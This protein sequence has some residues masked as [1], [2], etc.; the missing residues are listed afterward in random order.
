[1]YVYIYM[2]KALNQTI[3]LIRY[4]ATW[5]YTHYHIQGVGKSDYFG[6]EINIIKVGGNFRGGGGGGGDLTPQG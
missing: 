6:A 5:L 1:M 3:Y 4:L 2:H